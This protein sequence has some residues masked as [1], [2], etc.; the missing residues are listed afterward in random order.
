M[1]GNRAVQIE[2]TKPAIGEV[3]MHFLAE[4]PLRTDAHAIAD[5][6][7]PDHQFRIDRRPTHRAVERLQILADAVKID[8]PINRTQQVIFRHM[9]LNA[10][11]VKQRLLHHRPL[12]HH[13]HVSA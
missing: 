13:Q 12:A 9:I 4:T 10:E 1:I 3:E 6:Q 7:H 2:P 8:E 5:D 11:A